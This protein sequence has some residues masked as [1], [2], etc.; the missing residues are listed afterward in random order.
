MP[1]SRVDLPAYRV[2]GDVQLPQVKLSA[3]V[4]QPHAIRLIQSM[5]AAHLRAD[6]PQAEPH[7]PPMPVVSERLVR[8]WVPELCGERIFR[9]PGHHVLCHRAAAD[10]A[11]RFLQNPLRGLLL[12]GQPGR[13][14]D[15]PARRIQEKTVYQGATPNVL[16][17]NQISWC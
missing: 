8:Q 6:R 9:A 2:Q 10:A 5:I 16:R 3:P 7:L 17:M 14:S 13:R 11:Y 1:G 15:R 12:P 4:D